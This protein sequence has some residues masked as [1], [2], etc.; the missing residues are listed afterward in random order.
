M[1]VVLFPSIYYPDNDKYGSNIVM[2][3]V[4]KILRPTGSPIYI[5][6]NQS[7]GEKDFGVSPDRIKESIERIY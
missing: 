4:M 7:Y 3:K 2:N 6:R 5:H 1:S